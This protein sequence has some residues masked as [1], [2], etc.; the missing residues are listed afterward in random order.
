VRIEEGLDPYLSTIEAG[1]ADEFTIEIE[2]ATLEF[3][4][5]PARQKGAESISGGCPMKIVLEVP[6][7]CNHGLVDALERLV[8]GVGRLSRKGVRHGDFAQTEVK[9]ASLTSRV[10]AEAIGTILSSL[11]VDA[12]FVRVD[13]RRYRCLGIEPKTYHTLAGKVTIER[14]LYRATDVRN[15]PTLD[16]IA[17][18][19]GMVGGCWLPGTAKAMAHGLAMVTSRE[20]ASN[21]AQT[22]RLP[23][24]RSSFER[25]GHLVGE[26]YVACNLDVEEELACDFEVPAESTSISVSLDRAAVPMEEIAANGEDVTRAFRMA[27]CGTLTFHDDEGDALHTIRYGRMPN[28][29]IDELDMTMQSDLSTFL[30]RRPGLRVVLLADGA[31]EMWNRLD[32]IAQDVADDAERRVD[33]W[34]VVEYLAEAAKAMCPPARAKSV[35]SRWK[36]LLLEEHE[37]VETILGELSTSIHPKVNRARRYLL[38]HADQMDYAAARAEGLPIG[39]GNVEATCK[40]LLSQRLK[41]SGSRWKTETGEHVVQLRALQISDRWNDGVNAALR[42]LRQPV[43]IAA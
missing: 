14:H 23:Y 10:E 29:D 43:R 12:P 33:F 8:D 27:H 42:P 35:L 39:S 21:A 18:R 38:N 11:D 16:P 26:Q 20:A 32:T 31:E 28:G 25:V 3:G 19:V 5:E 7:H 6:D 34:H 37:A 2:A 22:G 30:A 24:S 40:S 17:A 4:A 15:G 13:G 36:G 1:A 9:V 41:R